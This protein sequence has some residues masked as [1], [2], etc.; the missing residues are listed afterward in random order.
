MHIG[1]CSSNVASQLPTVHGQGEQQQQQD[2][3]AQK[4][5]TSQPVVNLKSL[6]SKATGVG[7][8]DIKFAGPIH[9]ATESWLDRATKK[10]KAKILEKSRA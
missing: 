9:I 1:G 7:A 3:A 2:S 10:A 4:L 8:N 6:S 5:E